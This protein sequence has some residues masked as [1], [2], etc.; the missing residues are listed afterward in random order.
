MSPP[1]RRGWFS[2][3]I[4]RAI[5][6]TGRPVEVPALLRWLLRFRTVRNLP[7]RLFGYGVRRE[8]VR[9]GTAGAAGAA[10]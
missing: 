3:V 5:T 4:S 10:A 6:E 8:R 9:T 1:A 7:A 2:G